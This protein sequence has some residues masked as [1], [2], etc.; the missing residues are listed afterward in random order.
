[1][2]EARYVILR[3]KCESHDIRDKNPD[4]FSSSSGCHPRLDECT[5][6][7]LSSLL[8]IRRVI[9]KGKNAA[10]TFDPQVIE[11]SG[12]IRNLGRLPHL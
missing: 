11:K 1:M 7:P 3:S 4:V 8:H 5:F 12:S 9:S 6:F 2:I 10:L